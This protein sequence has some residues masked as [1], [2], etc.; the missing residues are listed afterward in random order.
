MSSS[1]L[2][3]GTVT[4][5]STPNVGSTFAVAVPLGTAHLP[6]DRIGTASRVSSGTIASQFL[7]EMMRWSPETSA[8]HLPAGDPNASN[9]GEITYRARP[10]AESCA[11]VLVADDNRDMREYLGRILEPGFRV[12]TVADGRQALQTILEQKPDLVI[13]DVMMPHLDGFAL[14]AALR[15]DPRTATIP[16]IMLSARAGEEARVEGLR[17]GADDYLIKPFSAREL[18]A[19]VSSNLELSQVRREASR[20]EG[21][22]EGQLRAMHERMETVFASVRD[23][24]MTF[25]A[26]WRFAYI[27]ERALEFLELRRQ[28]VIGKPVWEVIPWLAESPLAPEM[29]QI[30]TERKPRRLE[31]R[32]E[33]RPAWFE[34]NLYP[35]SDGV[36]LLATDVTERKRNEQL[37]QESEARMSLAV[38]SARMGLWDWDIKQDTLIWN[39]YHELIM[40]YEPGTPN[41]TYRDF[42]DRV[43]PDDLPRLE[44]GFREAIEK[45]GEYQF[46]HKVVWPGGTIR[47][48]DARGH[49]FYND[50]GEAVRSLGIMTDITERKRLENELEER[51]AALLEDDRRKNEFL[52]TLAHELRNPL[53]PL[54]SG[55]EVMRL[56]ENDPAMVTHARQMMDRQ[57]HQMVRLVDDLLDLS[58][59]SRGKVEL[60]MER[61]N[62]A[63]VVASA[64]ETSRPLI[65]QGGHELRVHLPAESIEIE[66]DTTRLA[67]VFANLLNNAAKYTERGGRIHLSVVRDGAE[68][69]VAVTD[70][71][72]GIPEAMLPR[73]FQ[74]FTQV[75]RSLD[76]SQG[77]L[78]I[79]LTIVKQLVELHGGK[80]VAISAGQGKGSTFVVTLPVQSARAPQAT[81]IGQR[82]GA[83]TTSATNRPWRILVVDDNRDAAISLSIMLELMGNETRTAHDGLEALTA[84]EHYR[85]D[86]VLLDIGMPRMNGYEAARRLRQ[87]P[88]GTQ[89]VLVALT[90]WGQAE[91][92]ER[93]R[94]AGFNHHLVKPVEISALETLFAELSTPSRSGG[95]PSRGPS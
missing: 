75:E 80:V 52:A 66:A 25:D 22:L 61:V 77:G 28:A 87:E 12:T 5:D 82:S 62:L 19:R 64:V 46:T 17:A 59:I 43:H 73:I 88:W 89:L 24:L 51:N 27:N 10:G 38:T 92:K 85:P 90:G 60:R 42:A 41:R 55:L 39:E 69:S 79:G 36:C 30:L 68:V 47:W 4:V 72:V 94:D 50:Q 71:G 84:A 13:T 9:A 33:P 29:K 49:F 20:R 44:A 45:R 53:A 58:R 86:I 2:H 78:G 67:Q 8:Q 81:A 95:S 1:P 3:G 83:A 15:N 34:I 35:L 6:A 40:G 54:R 32:F 31:Y 56:A 70:N 76:R 91:D 14:L 21:E 63:D 93:S 57:V 65:E 16:I 18:L 7:D 11:H 37:L 74:M 26:E 23:L 48:V